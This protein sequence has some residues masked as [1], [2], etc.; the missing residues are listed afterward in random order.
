M[1]DR[2]KHRLTRT[3]SQRAVNNDTFMK[4]QMEG[5]QRVMPAG[6]INHIVDVGEQF[7]QERQNTTKYRFVHT[8]RTLMSNPLFNITG[9]D[10]WSTFNQ[11]EF[12]DDLYRS[13]FQETLTYE[14]SV[15]THLKE[16][17]GWFGY[18]SVDPATAPL[19]PF[20]EMEPKK[21][22]FDFAPKTG[23]QWEL[24]LTYPYASDDT[25]YLVQGGLKIVEAKQ[26]TVGGRTML[27]LAVPVY[28]NLTAGDIVRINGVA[29]DVDG[30]HVVQRIGDDNGEFMQNYFCIDVDNTTV[31]AGTGRM[32]R[33]YAGEESTY[34]IRKFKKLNTVNGVIE[35]DDY[36]TYPLAFSKNMWN[37]KV[38]Q[39]VFNEDIEIAGLR[40]N[41][42][43]PLSEVFL[44]VVKTSDSGF[45]TNT[46][47]GLDLSF[48]T[49]A[50]STAAISNIRR[51]HDGGTTP[52][53]SHTPLDS[54]VLITD[55]D[56]DGDVAEYNRYQV[57]ETILGN[58]MHRFNT[59]N[60]IGAGNGPVSGGRQEGYIYNP[61]YKIKLREYSVYI[62]QGDESTVG[63]PDYAEDLGDGRW[64]W[65]DMLDIGFNDGND[66]FIDYPF[67]NGS[68]YIHEN[69][70]FVLKR[71]DA[72]DEYELYSGS[73][74][75][76]SSDPIGDAISDRFN[77]RS[78]DDIC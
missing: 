5:S 74:G 2:I 11:T 27:G 68:H 32:K 46:K 6:E 45:F 4:I 29:T 37:D 57:K 76:P 75:D 10:T 19:C 66:D 7:Y 30:D 33:V 43:R 12:K 49:D 21:E 48:L 9:T 35:D 62:E 54:S 24:T 53:Q 56:F 50:L 65:R 1:S 13:L 17:N 61:H 64:L 42:G 31:T 58:I 22:R 67:L 40:D 71:Q 72:F 3:N 47:S 51:I 8:I 77:V 14:K 23:K 16:M 55:S 28:H 52:F 38:F 25:H 69:I 34:Y 70:C 78:A 18:Y 36:E 39:T 60:R 63:I 73:G 15:K 59:N 41:L 26:V 20:I 44:T